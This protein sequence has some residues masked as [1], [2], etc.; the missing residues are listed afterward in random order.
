MNRTSCAR[1]LELERSTPPTTDSP[2]YDRGTSGVAAAQL[3]RR[4]RL[5][6]KCVELVE[7]VGGR[8]VDDAMLRQQ[9]LP[10]KFVCDDNDQQFCAATARLVP[11]FNVARA[12]LRDQDA[13]SNRRAAVSEMI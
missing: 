10:M 2:I 5:E 1:S 6:A 12:E 8:G 7:E 11:N 4:V 3:L 13:T 9:W